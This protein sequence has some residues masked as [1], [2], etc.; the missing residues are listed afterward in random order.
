MERNVSSTGSWEVWSPITVYKIGATVANET[1]SLACSC[2]HSHSDQHQKFGKN[3]AWG[4]VRSV[5]AL[6]AISSQWL[7]ISWPA[8][9]SLMDFF[10][11]NCF[12]WCMCSFGV[13]SILWW[14]APQFKLNLYGE[15]IVMWAK[16]LIIPLDAFWLCCYFRP[17]GAA[18][19]WKRHHSHSSLIPSLS[20][21]M[22]LL[23]SSCSWCVTRDGSPAPGICPSWTPLGDAGAAIWVLQTSP[24]RV[25]VTSLHLTCPLRWRRRERTKILSISNSKIRIL[26]ICCEFVILSEIL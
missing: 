25:T 3:W 15:M 18:P 19:H 6:P 9:V 21:F 17:C 20:L 12:F 2:L 16:P 1:Q 26:K 5:S 7:W 13:C 24:P 22:E 8:V 14:W 23:C 11:T 10:S 4:G